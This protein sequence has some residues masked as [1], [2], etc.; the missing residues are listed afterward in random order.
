MLKENGSID[1]IANAQLVMD[2]RASPELGGDVNVPPLFDMRE[3]KSGDRIY[4]FTDGVT[5]YLP[6]SVLKPI[7][8][9]SDKVDA[10]SWATQFQQI[11]QAIKDVEVTDPN[12]ESA[13][14]SEGVVSRYK[15]YKP[16][17]PARGDNAD[18]IGSFCFTIP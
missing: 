11:E 18:D 14:L 1:Y 5:D 9:S 8:R 16:Y 2:R 4:G 6:L 12:P 3:V 7:L 17:I 10:A 15:D 13:D